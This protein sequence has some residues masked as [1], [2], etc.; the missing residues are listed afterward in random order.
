MAAT[1]LAER[2]DPARQLWP[3]DER[4]ILFGGIWRFQPHKAAHYVPGIKQGGDR[5]E[6]P[7]RLRVHPRMM[8]Q[9]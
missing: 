6:T 7:L 1:V 8:L 3:V 5:L 4:Y 2:P 9:V